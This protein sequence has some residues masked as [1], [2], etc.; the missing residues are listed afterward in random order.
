MSSSLT[1]PIS[2][3]PGEGDAFSPASIGTVNTP[4]KIASG[5]VCPPMPTAAGPKYTLCRVWIWVGQ[6][7]LGIGRNGFGICNYGFPNEP[8]VEFPDAPDLGGAG[9]G[10]CVLAGQHRHGEHPVQ[11]RERLGVSADAD[12]R[13]AEIHLVPG[14]DMGRPARTRHR[15][16]RLRHLQLRLP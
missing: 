2:E 10:R 3:E 5:W 13:R 15:S 6:P 8:Y 12:G 4:Y 1:P 11:D 14:V 9:R 16:Q 7:E